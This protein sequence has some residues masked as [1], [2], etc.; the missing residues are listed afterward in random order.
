MFVSYTLFCANHVNIEKSVQ[1]HYSFTIISYI[2]V[3]ILPSTLI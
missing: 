3:K 2:V 1:D